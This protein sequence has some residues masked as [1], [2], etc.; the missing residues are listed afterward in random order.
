MPR[1]LLPRSLLPPSPACANTHT[2]TTH[3]P[4]QVRQLATGITA[5]IR[6]KETGL[7]FDK[8][9]RQA[10]FL[11]TCFLQLVLS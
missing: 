6:F 3:L 5:R 1:S 4:S 8:D 10:R 9:P 11:P 7:L 2:T